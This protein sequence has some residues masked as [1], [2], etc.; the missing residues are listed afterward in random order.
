[1]LQKIIILVINHYKSYFCWQIWKILLLFIYGE[2]E[3]SILTGG[4]IMDALTKVFKTISQ[5]LEI[6]KQFFKDI[7][8]EK[9]PAEG[10]A[11]A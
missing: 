3:K 1:M 2:S 5:V 7:F 8:P 6:I 11:N 4:T 9:D 10:D